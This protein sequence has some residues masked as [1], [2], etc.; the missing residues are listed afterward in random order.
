MTKEETE[1]FK[2]KERAVR[3]QFKNTLSPEEAQAFQTA[4][5]A[6]AGDSVQESMTYLHFQCMKVGIP[7][8]EEEKKTAEGFGFYKLPFEA[9]CTK[10]RNYLK[11]GKWEEMCAE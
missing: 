3:E 10:W 5:D 7:W 11:T 8:T 6:V 4:L 1:A 2:A 9:R